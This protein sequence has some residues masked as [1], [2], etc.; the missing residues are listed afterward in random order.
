M[1]ATV[2]HYSVF[3]SCASKTNS[4]SSNKENLLAVSCV[5]NLFLA[6]PATITTA[7]MLASGHPEL[8]IKTLYYSTLY[9]GL[10]STQKHSHL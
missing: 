8:E 4:G 7:L 6:V 1:A 9:I 5:V 2:M 10:Y 3:R